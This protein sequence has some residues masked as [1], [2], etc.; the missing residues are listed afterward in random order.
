MPPPPPTHT[1]TTTHQRMYD[2]ILGGG[3]GKCIPGINWSHVM[4]LGIIIHV[5]ILGYNESLL[6][7]W[8]VTVQELIQRSICALRISSN[9]LVVRILPSSHFSLKL[10]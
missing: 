3:G 6:Y 5:K 2:F 8:H 4:S 7:G 10:N 1:H 9:V